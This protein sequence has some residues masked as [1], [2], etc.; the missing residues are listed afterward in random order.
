MALGCALLR[1]TAP[2]SSSAA[3]SSV[4]RV[5]SPATKT[6]TVACKVDCRARRRPSPP[7]RGDAVERRGT[8]LAQLAAVTRGA[9]PDAFVE[10]LHAI[11][12]EVVGGREAELE[13]AA[14][15]A[16]GAQAG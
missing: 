3:T 10:L 4:I 7:G 12:E 8:N 2:C 9:A 14:P 11:E 5:G 6:S 16:L 15:R 1:T 13:V